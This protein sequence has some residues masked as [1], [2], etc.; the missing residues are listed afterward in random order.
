MKSN[1]GNTENSW[2][3]LNKVGFFRGLTLMS[4][5]SF[6]LLPMQQVAAH[7]AFAVPLARQYGCS[8]EGG[9]YWPEDG[10]KIP[11]AGCKAAY[12][13]GGKSYYPFV[14]WDEVT[15]NPT[16]PDDF[17]TVEEAVPNGLLCAGGDK[18]KRGLDVPPTAGWHKSVIEPKDGKFQ[19]R[20]DNTRSHN[21]STMR[22]YITKP[23]Y[24]QSK[25][26]H[27]DDLEML[28]NVTTPN[29]VP[30]NGK[31]LS[32]DVSSFYYLD[33][34][35]PAD[36]TGDAMIYGIW[37]R[38]DYG[39]E[40]FF[41]CADVTIKQDGKK[42]E[43]S[44][45]KKGDETKPGNQWVAEKSFLQKKL[46]PKVGDKVQFRV[47]A[48]TNGQKVVDVSLPIT[49]KNVKSSNWAKDL[50]NLLNN[51]HKNQVKVGVQSGQNVKYNPENVKTNKVWLKSGSSSTM[52]LIKA[53]RSN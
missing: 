51:K 7:G 52:R 33:V 29:P 5:I 17:A 25:Q 20:W 28:L 39:H 45:D 10:S 1:T 2:K 41:N 49:S 23:S 19:L 46:V 18:Q 12:L 43:Q 40:A 32:S 42:I 3:G 38:I 4:A 50:A 47:T 27:W 31:G 48:G 6:V 15:A 34:P 9:Y 21:P 22:I 36:R 37:Q 35:I 53:K 13:A 26:L 14:Q 11:N 24:D 30:A 8:L 16:N 44:N